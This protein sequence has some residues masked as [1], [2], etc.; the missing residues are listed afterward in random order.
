MT[1]SA[2]VIKAF[3]KL[4]DYAVDVVAITALASLAYAP[5]GEASLQVLAGA[6]ASIAIGKRYL[7]R[8]E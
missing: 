8:A 5:S 1:L 7:T 6:I 4:G 3:S 2:D